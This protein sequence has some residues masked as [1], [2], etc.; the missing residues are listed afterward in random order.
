[1]L[2]AEEF[3]IKQHKVRGRVP[4]YDTCRRC[5]RAVL[6]CE[7]KITF[8]TRK[9]AHKHALLINIERNWWP[10][11]CLYPYRCRYC[12]AYHLTTG[13]QETTLRRIDK[14]YRRWLRKTGQR[15]A[16]TTIT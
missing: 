11:A 4:K 8:K 2:T 10:D 9:E 6:E 15:L 1:M 16:D 7:N 13:V 5:E 12:V 14:M 3:H